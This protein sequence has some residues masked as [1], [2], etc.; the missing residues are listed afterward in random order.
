MS[1]L[2]AITTR[3]LD[4]ATAAGFPT[5]GAT[6]PREMQGVALPAFFLRLFRVRDYMV[7]PGMDPQQIRAEVEVVVV[8]SEPE[9]APAVQAGP[10]AGQAFGGLAG[11]QAAHDIALRVI[12]EAEGRPTRMG[13]YAGPYAGRDVIVTGI[14]SEAHAD[15]W[16]N[17][18]P[19]SDLAQ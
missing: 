17:P 10:L 1:L 14:V 3:Y 4:A 16:A 5:V 15:V 19:L 8:T 7:S 11:A 18:G 9:D 13:Q 2:A 6:T 12:G